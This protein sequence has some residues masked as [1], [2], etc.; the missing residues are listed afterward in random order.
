[1]ETP[2]GSTRGL[3][4]RSVLF[5]ALIAALMACTM[6]GSA[7]TSSTG[8]TPTYLYVTNSSSNGAN[9]LSA[10]SIDT[11]GALTAITSGTFTTGSNPENVAVVTP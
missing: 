5:I 1:M 10:H 6:P 2:S 7:G 8:S 3:A 11:G 9:G 4:W